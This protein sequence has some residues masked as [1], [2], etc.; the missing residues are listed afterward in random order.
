MDHARRIA[1]NLTTEKLECEESD[2]WELTALACK[3]CEA[4]GAYRSRAGNTL[5]FMT[6]GE[7]RLS[8]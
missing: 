3:L 7:V 1:R 8:K 4:G 2:T 6:F 5:V